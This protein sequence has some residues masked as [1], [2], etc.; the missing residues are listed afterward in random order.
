VKA[1]RRLPLRSIPVTTLSLPSI[2]GHNGV[3]A[4]LRPDLSPDDDEGLQ[5]RADSLK[6]ALQGSLIKE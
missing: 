1:I 3:F 6:T 2:V 4:V 5:I